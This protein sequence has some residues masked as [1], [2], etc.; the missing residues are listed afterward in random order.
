M[1]F[2]FRFGLDQ[3]GGVG[4]GLNDTCTFDFSSER[5]SIFEN[6]VHMNLA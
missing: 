5:G 1:G 4:V 6:T 2:M 3:D